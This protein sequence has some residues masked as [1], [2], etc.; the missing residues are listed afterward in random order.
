MLEIE[1]YCS[2][3]YHSLFIPV[4][5][6]ENT[7]M[8]LCFPGQE[9]DTLPPI[10]YLT[11]L[12]S[13]DKSISYTMTS[14]YSYYGCIKVEGSNVIIIIG[15]INNVLYTKESLHLMSRD[16][17]INDFDKFS[18]FFC[19]IPTINTY[20]FLNILLFINYTIN[21]TKLTRTDIDGYVVYPE[22]NTVNQTYSQN[23]Y[24]KK[25]EGNNLYSLE[26]GNKLMRYVETGNLSAIK[27]PPLTSENMIFSGLASTKL[28]HLRNLFIITVFSVHNAAVKGGLSPSIAAQMFEAYIQQVERLSDPDAITAL[29]RQTFIDFTSRVA[30]VKIPNP[31]DTVLREVIQYIRSNTNKNIT[32][33]EIAES[34][35]Y[36]RSYLSYKFKN[37]IG[38][39]LSDY[40]RKCKLEESK[41]LLQYTNKTISEISTYLCFSSQSHFQRAFKNQ[42]DITPQAY[43]KSL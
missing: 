40:I 33:A 8:A 2:Y 38:S 5:V 22:N 42:F 12:G 41:D 19:N 20:A 25:E 28:R 34:V 18:S 29:I 30:D 31:T 27:Q 7:T 6:Y 35:G 16:F 1:E 13:T 36:N 15:P 26:M 39:N 14:F 23:T 9:N 24:V 43:R 3:L 37:E 10:Q 11:K 32:V 21:H 4:Y 17:I